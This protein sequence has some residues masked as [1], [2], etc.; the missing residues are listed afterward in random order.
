[1]ISIV[2][3]EIIIVIMGL[4][5]ICLL[6]ILLFFTHIADRFLQTFVWVLF[7]Y[8]KLIFGVVNLE[9]LD[10][11]CSC[12]LALKLDLECFVSL[13]GLELHLISF[14]NIRVSQARV[15]LFY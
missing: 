3:D 4:W 2:I 9:S 11:L 6:Y 7:K 10:K 13:F 5:F 1:M 8:L 14:M 12:G 15:F